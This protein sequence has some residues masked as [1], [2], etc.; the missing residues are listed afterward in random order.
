MFIISNAACSRS[1]TIED[2]RKLEKVKNCH[3]IV[4]KTCTLN[5]IDSSSN[6]HKYYFD[7]TGAVNS[8][9]LVNYGFNYYRSLKF[10]KPYVISIAGTIKELNILF[11][12]PSNAFAYEINI[13]CP[14]G[15]TCTIEDLEYLK[16]RGKKFGLKLP[17][18]ITSSEI[19]NYVSKIDLLKEKNTNLIYVVC[20]NTIPMGILDGIEGSLS[21]KYIQPISLRNVKIFRMLLDESID[22]Y[23]C[24]GISTKNDLEKYVKAGAN[25]VQIGTFFIQKGP[26]IFENIYF[27]DI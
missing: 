12:L 1:A 23:G 18:L 8:I 15:P 13:S 16:S 19:E 10:D 6:N 14:N 2:L 27:L 4:T 22:I 21:G 5:S 26:D 24:G 9:G 7:G 25:G 20:S 3:R 17:P 11:Y